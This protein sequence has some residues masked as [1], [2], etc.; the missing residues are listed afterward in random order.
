VLVLR[1]WR[2]LPLSVVVAVAVVVGGCSW[3]GSLRKRWRRR[4]AVE[5]RI[6]F[7]THVYNISLSVCQIKK[8]QIINK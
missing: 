2:A 6:N 4:I 1:G 5:E 3:S 7:Q 8:N